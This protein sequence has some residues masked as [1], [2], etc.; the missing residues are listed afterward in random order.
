MEWR[1]TVIQGQGCV[2]GG[3]LGVWIEREGEQNKKIIGTK[4]HREAAQFYQNI[5]YLS[6]HRCLYHGA[7]GCSKSAKWGGK[8]QCKMEAIGGKKKTRA[9][10]PQLIIGTDNRGGF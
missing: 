4:Y 8:L 6:M 7:I 2:K 3:G 9:T 5:P 10:V 1:R